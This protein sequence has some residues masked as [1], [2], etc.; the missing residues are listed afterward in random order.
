MKKSLVAFAAG[1]LMLSGQFASAQTQ[2]AVDAAAGRG[3]ETES[4]R[5]L[6]T[7]NKV[8]DDASSQRNARE[9]DRALGARF[10]RAVVRTGLATHC[11][12]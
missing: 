1:A 11:T 6:P 10:E 9:F 5:L 4:A 3:G 12:P 2:G 7:V 8:N